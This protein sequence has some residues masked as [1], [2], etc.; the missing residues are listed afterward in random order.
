M[1]PNSPVMMDSGSRKDLS[2][3]NSSDR[4]VKFQLEQL[5]E[6]VEELG[7]NINNSRQQARVSFV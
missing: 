5:S 6:Q 7:A 1:A 2:V 4:N 3:S